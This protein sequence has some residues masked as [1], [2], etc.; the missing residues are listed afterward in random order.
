[1]SCPFP[2]TRN[3]VLNVFHMASAR[4]PGTVSARIKYRAGTGWE[5]GRGRSLIARVSCVFS[6]KN[7]PPTRDK[8]TY[9]FFRREHATFD[10]YYSFRGLFFFLQ[11]FPLG[12]SSSFPNGTLTLKKNLPLVDHNTATFTLSPQKVGFTAPRLV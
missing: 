8:R 9:R 3:A 1:M 7:T 4:R 10:C 2:F 11:I 5:S 12:P 6:R